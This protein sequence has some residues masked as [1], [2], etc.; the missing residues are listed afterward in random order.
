MATE[1]SRK[2]KRRKIYLVGIVVGVLGIVSLV[3]FAWQHLE[4]RFVGIHQGRVMIELTAWEHEYGQVRNRQEA[5]RAIDM[6]EYVQSYYVP[7]PG[8]RSNP[9]MEAKLESQRRQTVQAIVAGLRQFTDQD[10]GPDA[11]KWRVWMENR[12]RAKQPAQ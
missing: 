3:L 2:M 11:Q 5:E 12:R 10:F 1:E 4:K 9:T 7:G 8:Y 6:L